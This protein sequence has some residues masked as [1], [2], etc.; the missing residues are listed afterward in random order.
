MTAFERWSEVCTIGDLLIRSAANHPNRKALVMP[1]FAI[2]YREL[3]EEAAAVARGIVG[4]GIQPRSHIGLFCNNGREFVT[5]LFG[6]LLANCVVVP[7]HARHKAHE[8]AYIIDNA[9]ISLLFSAAADTRYLDFREVLGNALP[10]LATANPGPLAIP[11]APHLRHVV[12]LSG[13]AANGFVDRAEFMDAGAG[14]DADLIDQLRRRTRLDDLAAI[15]YTSG[16]TANPKGCM[17]THEAMTRGPVERADSRFRSSDH[18]VTWGGGPLFHIGSLAP[19]LGSIGTAGTYLTDSFFDPDRAIALMTEQGVTAFWPWFPAILQPLMAHPGFDAA[20][21]RVRTML[22]IGPELLVRE[23]QDRLPQAEVLQG[24]GM[25]ETAGIFAISDPDETREQRATSHGKAVPGVEVRII[26]METGEDAPDGTVG[27]ILVRGYCVT[28]G[29]YRD[30]AKTAEAIDEDGWLHTGD[31]YSRSA[32]GSLIFN[33]R[34]KDMLKVGGENVAAIEVE[35][36]LCSHPAVKI[37]EVI[38]RPDERMD[39]VPVAFVELHPG[40]SANEEELI[41][42]CRGKI[43]SYK[44]PRA[45]YFVTAEEWPMSAT[46]VNKVAL[47]KRL[48]EFV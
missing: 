40:V 10:S 26:D 9:Q 35:A 12:L 20:T 5:G 29:Y 27:E 6:A 22:F 47:R 38:G 14:I 2:T 44:V 1:E 45:I 13:D 25:T 43:A 46:K 7:L 42:H 34:A 21:A 16:T 8:L 19:F 33:G 11:E 48:G 41:G 31:L 18:D 37:A 32:D 30:P 39:E 28:K 15:L 24:C 17:L 36:F 4:L 3:L 23:I